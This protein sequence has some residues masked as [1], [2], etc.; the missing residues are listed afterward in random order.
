MGKPKVTDLHTDLQA[1]VK[2][3]AITF[4][5]DGTLT[6]SLKATFI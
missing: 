1:I 2:S 5:I 4:Y 6:T 3:R